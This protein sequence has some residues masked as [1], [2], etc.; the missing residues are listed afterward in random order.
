MRSLWATVHPDVLASLSWSS[1]VVHLYFSW[2]GSLQSCVVWNHLSSGGHPDV[3]MLFD[4]IVVQK[5]LIVCFFL[6]FKECESDE[7]PHFHWGCFYQD[8]FS[9]G[10]ETS[11][12]SISLMFPPRYLLPS[13]LGVLRSAC[14]PWPRGRLGSRWRPRILGCCWKWISSE[15]L[16]E[17]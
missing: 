16:W 12:Q 2:L 6:W 10:D 14:F 11:S 5:C 13:W 17:V 9:P 15:E 3:Q 7:T 4:G 1:R 8:G